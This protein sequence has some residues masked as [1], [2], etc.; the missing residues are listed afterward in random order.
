MKI[1]GARDIDSYTHKHIHTKCTFKFIFVSFQNGLA[2]KATLKKKKKKKKTFKRCTTLWRL[3]EKKISKTGNHRRVGGVVKIRKSS[4]DISPNAKK[5][6]KIRKMKSW[7]YHPG[8][9][10]QHKEQVIFN[11]LESFKIYKERDNWSEE[12]LLKNIIC[13]QK[14]PKERR[15]VKDRRKLFWWQG[16]T[17]HPTKTFVVQKCKRADWAKEKENILKRKEYV[18][19]SLRIVWHLKERII[20]RNIRLL[21]KS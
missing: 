17:G 2:G 20:A 13:L 5:K 16:K 12:Y 7:W 10:L 6:K 11:I 18:K 19:I 15:D 4:D 9:S 8:T 3:S 1:D 14:N 21:R